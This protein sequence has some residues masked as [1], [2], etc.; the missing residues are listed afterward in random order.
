MTSEQVFGPADVRKTTFGRPLQGGF[1]WAASP[2][3]K[4]W[5]VV[6]NRFAVTD[7]RVCDPS[8]L[9]S[10]CFFAAIPSVSSSCC[11]TFEHEDED[12]KLVYGWIALSSLVGHLETW[13][14]V[15]SSET[16]QPP[17]RASIKDTALVIC[18]T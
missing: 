3:L 12:D 8:F 4:P 16:S 9:R 11:R 6:F 2:G 17:P 7:K 18:R 14:G 10:L 1:K 15:G 13:D 5:A